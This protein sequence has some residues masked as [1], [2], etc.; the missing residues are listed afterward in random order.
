MDKFTTNQF[1]EETTAA[2]IYEMREEHRLTT[3]G[4]TM[5]VSDLQ[6]AAYPQSPSVEKPNSDAHALFTNDFNKT[7]FI[8]ANGDVEIVWNERYKFWSVPAFA[9][10]RA[11]YGIAKQRACDTWGCE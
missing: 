10:S 8:E 3:E 5:R 4:E 7:S 1:A 6:P 2:D 11:A 9:E